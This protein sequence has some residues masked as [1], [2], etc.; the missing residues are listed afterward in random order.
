MKQVLNLKKLARENEN[1]RKVLLTGKQSQIVA[2]HLAPGEEI[3][4][5][6]HP[7]IDQLFLVEEGRAELLIDGKPIPIEE[8]E[9]ALAPAGAR[10]NLRN[11]GKKPLKCVTFYAPPVHAPNAVEKHPHKLVS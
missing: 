9:V 3:G 4:D 10:H 11:A 8:N 2:M 5:E 1:F 7:T 6:T